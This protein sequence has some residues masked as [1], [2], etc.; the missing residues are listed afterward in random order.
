MLAAGELTLSQGKDVLPAAD[1]LLRLY[2]DWSIC[3]SHTP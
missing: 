2:Y 3:G 1:E